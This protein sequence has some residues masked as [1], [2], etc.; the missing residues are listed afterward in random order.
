MSD[1]FHGQMVI[2]TGTSAGI[3]K[4]LGLRLTSQVFLEP[5]IRRAQ[6]GSIRTGAAHPG[7]RTKVHNPGELSPT[8]R[9]GW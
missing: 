6:G 2:L 9:N 8:G 7:W 4:S 5:A 3:G 1:V